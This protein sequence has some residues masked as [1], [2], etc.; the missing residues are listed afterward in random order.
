MNNRKHYLTLLAAL[1]SLGSPLAA[2]TPPPAP[3][4]KP[5]DEEIVKLDNFEV[6]DVPIEENIMPTSRPFNSVFGTDLNVLDTPRN[7]TIISRAQLDAIGVLETRDFSKLTASSYTQTNFGLPSNPSIRGLT[8]DVLV[9]GMRRGLTVNGN[10]MPINF[11]SVESINIVKGT[12]NV[13]YGAS[14]YAGGYADFVTKKPYFDGNRGSVEFTAGSYDVYRW[15]ADYGGPLSDKFAYRFS[16]SGEDS[17]GYYYDGKKKTQAIYGAGEWRPNDRYTLEFNTEYFVADFTE[18]WGINRVTQDLIDKGLYIPDA[19]SDA[20]YLAA[21]QNIGGGFNFVRPKGTPVKLDRRRRLLAPGDDSYGINITSQAIQTLK[22]DPDTRITN[23]TFFNYIDRDTFSSYYYN[24]IHKDNWA[25]ENRLQYEGVFTTG[26]L[27]HKYAAGFSYRHQQ[28][29]AVDDFW[30]EPVNSFDLTRNPDFN[31]V[32]AS[33]FGDSNP[34]QPPFNNFNPALPIPGYGPRGVLPTRYATPG[35][36]YGFDPATGNVYEYDDLSSNDST[37]NQVSPFYQHDL[38]INRK[39]S[40]LGGVRADIL[41]VKNTDPL[42][43]PGFEAASDKIVVVMPSG[44]FSVVY[45]PVDKISTYYTFAYTTTNRAGPLGGGYTFTP[46]AWGGNGREF[47]KEY[48]QQDN[49]LHEIGSKLSLMDNKLFIGTAIY[50]QDQYDKDN[51]GKNRWK[52]ARGF[53]LEANYQ[54]SRKY[55]VTSSYSYFDSRQRFSGFL[56]DSTSYDKRSDAGFPTGGQTPD[57]PSIT[58]S[59]KQPGIPEHLFN[60][61]VGY[62]FDSGFSTTLS[63]VVTGP[64]VTSQVGSGVASPVVGGGPLSFTA[65]E[66]PW[67]YTIDASIGYTW[68]RWSTKL[69]VRNVTDEENWS[70]PNPGYGNGSINADPDRTYEVTVAYRF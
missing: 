69:T 9:N 49:Y 23:N 61:L 39:L 18:N 41:H 27:D 50:A 36:S 24:S 70:S 3:A 57:F 51:G 58:S 35:A 14:S 31:R 15:T 44:N 30:H 29:W 68:K 34:V 16:Y 5:A 60:F 38:T 20:A 63:A 22:I 42:P 54:P 37:L 56:A 32:P 28:V 53:E 48:F 64:M 25:V 62:K 33:A 13:I 7:V 46:I 59:F 4:T 45:K 55:F 47:T 66:I 11:N 6:S 10:G 8:A 52:K 2:Q 26:S 1:G 43:P 21:V 19:G 40:L 67:Q 17:R 12:G 65:N